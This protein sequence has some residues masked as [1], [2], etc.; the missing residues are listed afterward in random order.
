MYITL[1]YNYKLI[2][3]SMPSAEHVVPISK[4]CKT[5]TYPTY[6]YKLGNIHPISW[7][8]WDVAAHMWEVKLTMSNLKL[9]RLSNTVVEYFPLS[10]VTSKSVYTTVYWGIL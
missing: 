9:S 4:L 1:Y 6:A 8:G 3:M 2:T 5:T 7:L 10:I